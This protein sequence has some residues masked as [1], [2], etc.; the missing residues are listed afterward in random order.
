MQAAKRNGVKFTTNDNT[1][2][3]DPLDVYQRQA[4]DIY[5]L[6]EIAGPGVA[7]NCAEQDHLHI[8][9][10]NF[11]PEVIDPETGEVLPEGEKG[12][13]VFTCITKEAMPLIRYRTKDLT[14][15]HTERCV[16]GRTTRCV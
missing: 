3:L 14:V 11:I 9:A 1:A 10:D 16:C 2:K 12:E 15:L 5:G 6:S 4:Y 7:M 13:L 8:Q